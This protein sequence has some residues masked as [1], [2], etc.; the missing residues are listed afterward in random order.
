MKFMG[1]FEEVLKPQP[2]SSSKL[3][4]DFEKFFS[5]MIITIATPAG[6]K[7]ILIKLLESDTYSQQLLQTH[8]VMMATLKAEGKA[9]FLT[10]KTK[11]DFAK[12]SDLINGITI[13]AFD[14]ETEQLIGQ[15]SFS[16]KN[17]KDEQCEVYE[18]DPKVPY[19]PEALAGFGC[20]NQLLEIKGTIVLPSYRGGNLSRELVNFGIKV[21]EDKFGENNIVLLAEVA[22]ENKANLHIRMKDGFKALKKYVASDG[23]ECYLLYKPLGEELAQKIEFEAAKCLVKEHASFAAKQQSHQA[24]EHLSLL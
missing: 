15:T 16:L 20:V 10:E 6:K 4:G 19:N 13:G 24:S 7:Q 17:L 9:Q 23:V 22:T 3:L 8:E 11:E 2:K 1:Y 12:L 14:I 18:G 21:L 5:G